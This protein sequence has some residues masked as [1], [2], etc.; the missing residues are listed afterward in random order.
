MTRQPLL[1]AVT[2]SLALGFAFT[3]Q[4]PAA[5]ALGGLAVVGY[6]DYEDNFTIV[7][8][9]DIAP[10]EIVYFTNN[11]WDATANAFNGAAANQGA[12]LES[13]LKLSFTGTVA[14]GTLMASTSNSSGWEWT[15]SG[16]IPGQ[17]G[18]LAEFGAL[19]IDYESDQIYAF[20][21]AELN[22]LMNP[23]N[24]IYAMHISSTAHPTFAD[25]VDTQSG[26][27]LP[28]LSL[29]A[30]TAS[31]A[32]ISQHGDADGNHSSW[33]INLNSPLVAA[34]QTSGN[35][36]ETWRSVIANPVAW[37]GAQPIPTTQLN[38]TPEPGRALMMLG[39]LV[40]AM[41]RRRRAKYL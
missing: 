35:T 34:I 26:A 39:G 21:A 16:V 8:L 33:G 31:L 22:P 11:G 1:R 15:S 29:A 14:A 32:G 30:G 37:T 24:F 12:G 2:A 41:L 23:T 6:D 38:I 17:I 9:Q 40:V 10:G 5:V 3:V 36:A 18:G 4:S 7:A 19:S 28:G 27:A 25:A 13:L 20:Q